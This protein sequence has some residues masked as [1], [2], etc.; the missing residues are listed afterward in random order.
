[1][2]L[3]PVTSEAKTWLSY[4]MILR[5][6]ELCSKTSFIPGS[7]EKAVYL[8]YLSVPVELVCTGRHP[9]I[10]RKCP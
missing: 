3:A 2:L 7:D 8:T 6:L 10:G 5:T 1:M 4:D 9:G